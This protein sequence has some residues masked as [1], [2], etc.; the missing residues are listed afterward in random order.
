[1]IAARA[2]LI[3]FGF[4][5][6]LATAILLVMATISQMQWQYPPENVEY[7]PVRQTPLP[8]ANRPPTPADVGEIDQNE[9]QA[10]PQQQYRPTL[11]PT[12]QAPQTY[13]P[14]VPI[15]PAPDVRPR[16]MPKAAAPQADAPVATEPRPA[17]P[18]RAA[19]APPPATKSAGGF[20]RVGAKI[21]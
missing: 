11:A 2:L 19:P 16:S 8:P 18:P 7:G 4:V 21:F 15:A 3:L 17:R 1:M 9:L 20:R 5:A 6:A 14:S 10:A 13:T 12:Y